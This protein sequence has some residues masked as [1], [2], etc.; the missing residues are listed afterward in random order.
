MHGCVSTAV[1]PYSMSHATGMD[2]IC[3]CACIVCCTDAT[4]LS[5]YTYYSMHSY[6]SDEVPIVHCRH[7]L[8]SI[9]YVE[10]VAIDSVHGVVSH[11]NIARRDKIT[12]DMETNKHTCITQLLHTM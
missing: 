10:V 9:H 12:S 3:L 2:V 11:C 6:L 5:P 1:Q 7:D 4:P 8:V